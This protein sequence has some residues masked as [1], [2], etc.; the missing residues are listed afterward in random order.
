MSDEK[1]ALYMKSPSRWPY[2]LTLLLA[3]LAVSAILFSGN[4][5]KHSREVE[6]QIR[7][8]LSQKE[9][10]LQAAESDIGK[11]KS[12][13]VHESDL[14]KEIEEMRGLDRKKLDDFQK[15]Y[16]LMVAGVSKIMASLNGSSTGGASTTTTPSPGVLSFEWWDKYKRFHLMV[17]NI[18]GSSD[19]IKF[20]YDQRFAVEAVLF[21]QNPKDGVLQVMNASLLELDKDG[22][23][24]NTAKIDL[25]KS[26]FSYSASLL[27]REKER[28]NSFNFGVT[29]SAEPIVTFEPRRF[30]HNSIGV[31]L[32]VFGTKSSAG[33]G[34]VGQWYPNIGWLQSEIAVGGMVG[35]STKNTTEARIFVSIP[36]G[37]IK[38]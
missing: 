26:K 33:A 21:R 30:Y 29:S 8:E 22:N 24:I 9:R 11:L 28:R 32:G 12:E 13:L 14:R 6:R 31:G 1:V 5:Y 18:Y 20:S 25:E 7:G 37:A 10:E 34:I 27:E 38:R 17:P 2:V 36:V 4:Q 15:R 35:Y 23:V 16:D 19:D 3:L